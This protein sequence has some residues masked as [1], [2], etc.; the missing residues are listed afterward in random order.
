MKNK[1][2]Y[3]LLIYYYIPVDDAGQEQQI[4]CDERHMRPIKWMDKKNIK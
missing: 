1:T 3:S 4:N 2:K